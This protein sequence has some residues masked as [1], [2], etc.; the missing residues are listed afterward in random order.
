MPAGMQS[1]R[2]ETMRPF[3]EARALLISRVRGK[4]ESGWSPTPER[5]ALEDL[6]SRLRA[7]AEELGGWLPGQSGASAVAC[8]SLECAHDDLHGFST[9]VGVQNSLFLLADTADREVEKLPNPR[10]KVALPF[11]ALG[12]LALLHAHGRDRPTKYNDG[13]GVLELESIATEAG[14]VVSR[15]AL[16]K[17]LGAALDEFEPD[18]LPEELLEILGFRPRLNHRGESSPD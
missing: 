13:W 11:A 8:S 16:R 1:A 4:H 10:I 14:I 5:K 9:Y 15:D 17:A 2:A 3:A 6:S 12:L 7:L 18:G